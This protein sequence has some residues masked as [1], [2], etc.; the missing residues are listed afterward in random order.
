MATVEG[1]GKGTA[2]E[3]TDEHGPS[4]G[5]AGAKQPTLRQQRVLDKY[6]EMPN[7][8]AVARDLGMS[9]RQVRRIVDDHRQLLDERRHREKREIGER[10]AARQAKVAAW[11]YVAQDDNL[12]ALDVLVRSPDEAI[13]LRAIKVRQDVIDHVIPPPAPMYELDAELVER[14]REAALSARRK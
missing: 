12:E 10:A 2:G 3:R 5:E 6:F 11:A 9:D 14:E 8:A 1:R 13:R 4:E 7:A